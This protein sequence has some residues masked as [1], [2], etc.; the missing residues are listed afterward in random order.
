MGFRRLR[1]NTRF[2]L[3]VAFLLSSLLIWQQ[4]FAWNFIGHAVIAQVAYD[5]LTPKAKQQVNALVKVLGREYPNVKSFQDVADWADTIK[6]DG[7]T[8]FNGWHFIDHGFSPTN[9]RLPYYPQENVAWAIQQNQ[10]TLATAKNPF[11]QAL[12]LA[13]LSHFVGDIEQPMHC[14]TRV[15]ASHPKGDQGGNLYPIQTSY[16]NNLH[17]L[18]DQGAGLYIYDANNSVPQQIQQLV[19]QIEQQYPEK[20][21]AKALNDPNP[22]HWADN[23]FYLAKDFAYNTP[24]GKAPSADYITKAQRIILQQSALAGYRLAMILNKTLS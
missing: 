16:A 19:Q 11:D 18:W 8:E 20:S 21:F 4:S 3:K 5:Q 1:I 7:V 22:R 14:V 23:S 12:A 6:Q 9:M 17:S 24:A 10:Q 2:F 15:T 13:F